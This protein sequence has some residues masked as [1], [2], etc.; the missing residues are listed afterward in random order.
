MSKSKF[1]LRL[2]LKVHSLLLDFSECL[3]KN[4]FGIVPKTKCLVSER[5]ANFVL[6]GNLKHFI[7][8]LRKYLESLRLGFL[9]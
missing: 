8:F 9:I 1:L 5:T 2:V 4:R 6:C 7:L 3:S